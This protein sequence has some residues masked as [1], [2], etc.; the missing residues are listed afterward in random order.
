M[1][2]EEPLYS[3]CS[4]VY[5]SVMTNGSITGF[6]ID[7]DDED[8]FVF[9]NW[10]LLA[11]FYIGNNIDAYLVYCLKKAERIKKGADMNKA[12]ER[13]L[14]RIYTL[15]KAMRND[16]NI[17]T[18]ELKRYLDDVIYAGSDIFDETE[19]LFYLPCHDN[20]N[21]VYIE[22]DDALYIPVYTSI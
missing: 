21:L 17:D 7:N 15:N 12:V 19:V 3:I 20:G 6:V 22:E 9:E 1:Y 10:W 16:P 2:K 11:L 4:K 13:F 8:R 14:E 18:K 5:Y